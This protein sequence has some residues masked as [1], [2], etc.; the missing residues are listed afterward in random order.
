M[1]LTTD[2][3]QA[4]ITVR[5]GDHKPVLMRFAGL[6]IAMKPHEARELADQLHDAVEQAEVTE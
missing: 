6:T 3:C 2:C 5:T 4:S 1:K